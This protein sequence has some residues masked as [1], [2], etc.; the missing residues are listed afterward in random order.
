[1]THRIAA[2]AMLRSRGT[3]ATA[4]T[5]SAVLALGGAVGAQD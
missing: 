5:L 4:L 2:G 1:M 3:T